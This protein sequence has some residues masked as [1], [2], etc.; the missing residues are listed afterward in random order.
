M[1][2]YLKSKPKQLD[3]QQINIDN[4][5]YRLVQERQEEIPRRGGRP[6][7]AGPRAARQPLRQAHHVTTPLQKAGAYLVTAKMADGNTSKIVLWLADTAIVRKPLHG[8]VVLLR[9][10]R[11]DRQADRQGQRRVLRLPAAAGRTATTFR[12]TPKTSPKPPTR[13]ARCFC[14]CR[15]T[16]RTRRPASTSGSPRPRRPTAGSRI[17]GFHNVWTGRYYDA[18]YNEV[19]TFAITDRPVYRPGPDGEVQ[20][21]GRARPSTMPRTSP[22]FAHQVVR[23]RDP[24]PQGREGLQRDAHGRRLRRHRRRV[25]AA[26]RRHAGRST[27]SLVVNRGGGTFRVEEYKKPEFEVTVDAPTEPVMLGEKITATIQREVLLRL[28]GHEREGEVQGDAHE[29]TAHWYP[30]GRGTG[31][32]APATGGS[33]TTTPGIPAGASGAACGRRRGGSGGSRRR[34]RSSPSAKCRSAPT[35]R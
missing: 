34:R 9:R 12:S 10:R 18:Q 35:A 7:E 6:V 16:A 24:Q 22:T 3:W 17:L 15:T 26:E 30:P 28:A 4:I 8:Q 11:R 27:R 19:K 29:H 1:K 31:S 33:P 23:G 14:R 32:T 21:L 13:T 5:G 2:A 20:V 25:R